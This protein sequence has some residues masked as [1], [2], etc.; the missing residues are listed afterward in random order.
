MR[1]F[2][3]AGKA[4]NGED[5]YETTPELWDWLEELG[6]TEF[7]RAAFNYLEPVGQFLAACLIHRGAPVGEALQI[8]SDIQRDV[9]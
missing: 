8:T 4:E 5:A 3:Y 7:E 6:A 9:L 1:G 2:R